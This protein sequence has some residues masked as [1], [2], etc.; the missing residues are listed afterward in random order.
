MFDPGFGNIYL[1][2]Q[3]NDLPS[4]DG[5]GRLFAI[6]FY[7][8]ILYYFVISWFI[9]AEYRRYLIWSKNLQRSIFWFLPDPSYDAWNWDPRKHLKYARIFSIPM[10]LFGS[11]M[12]YS[13]F[14]SGN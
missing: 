8:Y 6:F 14:F 1:I 13:V 5:L 10:V 7:G 3:Q 9:P 4:S 12:I 2:F 11:F